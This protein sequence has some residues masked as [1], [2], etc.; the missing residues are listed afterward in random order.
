ML[1]FLQEM[2]HRQPSRH[3]S[4]YP[5][6]NVRPSWVTDGLNENQKLVWINIKRFIYLFPFFSYVSDHESNP[7]RQSSVD[8]S[9]G[10]DAKQLTKSS[11]NILK[12]PAVRNKYENS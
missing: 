2:Q 3:L 10:K 7:R 1:F 9:L 12:T 5:A 6:D 8:D 4:E 11:P